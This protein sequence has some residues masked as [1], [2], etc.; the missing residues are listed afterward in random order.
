MWSGTRL[1]PQIMTLT[2]AEDISIS[3][4]DGSFL[5]ITDCEQNN[6]DEQRWRSCLRNVVVNVRRRPCAKAG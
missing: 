3:F 4:C 1:T 5:E 2:Q 6:Y